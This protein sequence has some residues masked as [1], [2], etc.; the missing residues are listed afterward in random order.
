MLLPEMDSRL[1]IR[2]ARH[3]VGGMA[4]EGGDKTR[5]VLMVA[6][7]LWISAAALLFVGLRLRLKPVL[8]VG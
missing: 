7:V 5:L 4:R 6:A 3:R 1:A 2:P 8:L